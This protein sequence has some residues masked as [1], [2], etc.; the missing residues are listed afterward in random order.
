MVGRDPTDDE[1]RSFIRDMLLNGGKLLAD[2]EAVED[3]LRDQREMW[4]L[5]YRASQGA[6]VDLPGA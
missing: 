2:P 4:V 1:L 5:I 3:A 6:E